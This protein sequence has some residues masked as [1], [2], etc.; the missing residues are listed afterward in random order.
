M[1]K[2]ATF[3]AIFVLTVL[4]TMALQPDDAKCEI[5]TD[6]LVSYWSFDESDID[7][8]KVKD[9]MGNNDGTLQGGAPQ[10]DGKIGKALEFDGKDDYVLVPDSDSLDFETNF[11][12]AAWLKTTAAQGTVMAKAPLEGNWAEGGKS[13]FVAGGTLHFDICCVTSP[14]GMKRVNDDE[15]HYFVMTIEFEF[16]GVDDRVLFYMDTE[17]DG[18]RLCDVN[19]FEDPG[20]PFKIGYTNDN[21]P[22][23]PYFTGIIDEVAVYSRVLSVDEIKENF[24]A[25]KGPIAVGFAGKLAGT[26]GEIKASR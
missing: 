20:H 6:E 5:V 13:L 15:W 11:T 7:G 1:R 23:M 24:D 9:A 12:W 2:K 14:D 22:G 18:E 19:R 3:A 25:T 21:F 17:P 26:W 4:L 10:V 8:E 16:S